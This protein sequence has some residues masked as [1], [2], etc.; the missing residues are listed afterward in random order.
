MISEINF[1]QSTHTSIVLQSSINSLGNS[2]CDLSTDLDLE[3]NLKAKEQDLSHYL[4]AR[5]RAPRDTF[6]KRHTRMV[7]IQIFLSPVPKVT[8]GDQTLERKASASKTAGSLTE[9][10]CNIYLNKNNLTNN[11]NKE[12]VC[13]AILTQHHSTSER[14][15]GFILSIAS[16]RSITFNFSD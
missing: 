9:G 14:R 13:L 4:A 7:L 1:L 3:V 15:R 6:G 12:K 11:N 16:K 8:P 2:S 10:M 5:Q